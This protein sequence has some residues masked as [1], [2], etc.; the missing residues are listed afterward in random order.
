LESRKKT[1][2]V[3]GRFRS[4]NSDVPQYVLRISQVNKANCPFHFQ[5]YSER[6]QQDAANAEEIFQTVFRLKASEF[7]VRNKNQLIRIGSGRKPLRR[8]ISKPEKTG[9]LIY[10]LHPD[11]A[12]NG[13]FHL[14]HHGRSHFR[15]MRSWAWQ[16]VVKKNR[17]DDKLREIR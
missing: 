5:I 17:N 13:I 2:S 4:E 16:R 6:G 3:V 15:E 12:T 14:T 9:R 11:L 7:E 10:R 1:T 8:L